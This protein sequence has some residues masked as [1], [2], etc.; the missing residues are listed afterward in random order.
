MT[1]GILHKIIV[2]LQTPFSFNLNSFKNPLF[3]L[4]E[5]KFT[6]AFFPR[7]IQILIERQT[8]LPGNEKLL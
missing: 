3:K 8:G 4:N 1:N 7:P 6:T 2:I 5:F